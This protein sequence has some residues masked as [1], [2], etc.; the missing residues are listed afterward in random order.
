M[1]VELLSR[2]QNS[3]APSSAD[4]DE[5]RW[6]SQQCEFQRLNCKGAKHSSRP[7][8]AAA[9]SGSAIRSTSEPRAGVDV[10]D[11][12]G[13]V[14]RAQA[15]SCHAGESGARQLGPDRRPSPAVHNLGA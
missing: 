2:P 3:T 6:A 12:V 10:C 11:E 14:D 4:S 5:D 9:M 1:R 13:C 8:N 15:T 7:V